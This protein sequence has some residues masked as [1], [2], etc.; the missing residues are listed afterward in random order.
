MK[1]TWL[2]LV[3]VALS[4]AV[5][6][7]NQDDKKARDEAF[8]RCDIQYNREV[9]YKICKEYLDKYPD[10]YERREKVAKFVRAYDRAM[11][12]ATALQAFAISKPGTW[13]I[14]EPDLKI[15][16]PNT[17]ETLTINRY[18]IEIDR[19]FANTAE[20]A[21]IK[22]AEAIYG[23]QFRYIDSMR[24]MPESW[25]D[26]L[27]DEIV[28]LWGSV[29]NDNVMVTDVITASGIKYYYDLSMSA[30][31]HQPFRNVFQ[32]SSTSLKY[33]ATSKHYAQ[34]EHANTKYHDV[35]VVDLNLEWSSICGGLCGVGFTRN[36]LV[37]FD[38]K[39]NVIEMYL[40]AAVN[41]SMWES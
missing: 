21:M 24:S 29:G 10:D 35:Y 8:S 37:V 36:K 6:G 4:P 16:L 28:P 34:W 23:G 40:D 3:L 2:V 5:L 1:S 18:K 14:Y 41:R 33:T 9:K 27:P 17:K 19:S 30:R 20:D 31:E 22:K 13:F 38:K 32:M 25:A 11:S 39:G 26:S 15:D 7:Q 12:Y